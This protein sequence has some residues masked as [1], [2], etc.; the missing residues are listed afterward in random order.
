MSRRSTGKRLRFTVF[1]R[2]GFTCQYC[3]S[4]PPAVVLVADH[5]LAVANGG[6]TVLDNLITS[7]EACNQG[8]SDKHLG[9][10]TP[11]L[12]GS[13][14]SLQAMQEIAELRQYQAELMA[15]EEATK[16][17]IETFED[18][19]QDLTGFDWVP[20]EKH[21]RSLV[22]RYSP[23]TVETSLRI[24]AA[25]LKNRALSEHGSRWLRYLYGTAKGVAAQEA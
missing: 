14:L 20:G 25:K 3:G 18:L 7:C 23:A 22:E 24:V 4:Q 9:S 10:K 17:L 16:E 1:H 12:D 11:P 19:W 13:L 2:D 5:I 15:K 6:A 21:M 8:K